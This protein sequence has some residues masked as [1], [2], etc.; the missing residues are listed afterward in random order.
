MGRYISSKKRKKEEER[1]NTSY[2]NKN[3]LF[4]NPEASFV[5]PEVEH[6]KNSAEP[7]HIGTQPGAGSEAPTEKEENLKQ[8][9]T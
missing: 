5:F 4:Y 9:I 3:A 2:V 6:R 8:I 7:P 1:V